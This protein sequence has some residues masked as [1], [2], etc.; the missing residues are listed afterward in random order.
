MRSFLLVKPDYYSSTGYLVDLT[1]DLI[2]TRKLDIEITNIEKIPNVN[3]EF[4]KEFYEPNRKASHFQKVVDYWSNKS[5]SIIW[6]Y[7]ENI[8]QKTFNL[9]GT[10]TD[11]LECDVNQIRRA[12]FNLI[13]EV[14]ARDENQRKLRNI[15]HRSDSEDNL[16]RELKLL[17]ELYEMYLTKFYIY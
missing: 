17:D 6:L 10:K 13:P 3:R 16:I 8:F 14:Y 11:P 9:A 2:R 15:V 5:S 4:I 1:R 7:G 12:A